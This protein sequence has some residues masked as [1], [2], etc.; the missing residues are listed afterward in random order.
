MTYYIKEAFEYLFAALILIIA[1]TMVIG[2]ILFVGDNLVKYIIV[3]Q[4][5]KEYKYTN[6]PNHKN[7][8]TG[9][10]AFALRNNWIY[11]TEMFL[12]GK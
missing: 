3:A 7:V 1:G 11:K 9:T 2:S 6:N 4:W 10:A 8:Y 5:P 12:K